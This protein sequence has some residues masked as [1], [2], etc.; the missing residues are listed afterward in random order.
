MKYIFAL[1]FLLIAGCSGPTNNSGPQPPP[2]WVDNIQLGKFAGIWKL[3]TLVD[4]C[5]VNVTETDSILIAS[6]GNRR[7]GEVLT[8]TGGLPINTAEIG[9]RLTSYVHAFN[10]YDSSNFYG[11][12]DSV[13]EPTRANCTFSYN[14]DTLFYTTKRG[15][16]SLSIICIRS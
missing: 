14:T 6:V 11:D 2:G 8:L 7:T 4:S 1:S 3:G 10:V 15:N 13:P 16:D 5:T 12:T 9:V